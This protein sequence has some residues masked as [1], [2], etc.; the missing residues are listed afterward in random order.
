MG[1]WVTSSC[2]Y[3]SPGP[4]VALQRPKWGSRCTLHC[5]A[6]VST[7]RSP[8]SLE[9]SVH[10]DC[11]V[12]GWPSLLLPCQVG[13][14]GE[15]EHP[16]GSSVSQPRRGTAGL[17][18]RSCVFLSVA[19]PGISDSQLG[20]PHGLEGAGL[21]SGGSSTRSCSGTG[22][23]YPDVHLFLGSCCVADPVLGVRNLAENKTDRSL[24]VGSFHFAEETDSQQIHKQASG[25]RL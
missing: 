15:G 10:S 17:D 9:G 25:S 13:K 3:V 18:A 5:G 19:C 7:L 16:Q 23:I 20:L 1:L 2:A 12:L 6:C 4:F 21:C 14:W 11:P 22:N 8:G 24:P